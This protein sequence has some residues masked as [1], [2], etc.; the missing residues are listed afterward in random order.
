[1]KHTITT[2][3]LLT[4]AITTIAQT[5]NPTQ[6]PTTLT[7]PTCMN[8]GVCINFTCACD[9]PYYGETCEL[10]KDCLCNDLTGSPTSQPTP[11]PTNSPTKQPT[12]YC[13]LIEPRPPD[14]FCG[15]IPTNQP[16]PT[17]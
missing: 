7:C 17:P 2:T 12:I 1:M 10:T 15:V 4:F 5:N 8:G 11:Q 9:Y 16:T 14:C 3:L 13:C 6:S